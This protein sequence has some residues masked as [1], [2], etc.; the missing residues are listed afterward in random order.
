MLLRNAPSE[1]CNKIEVK[2]ESRESK[3]FLIFR[4]DSFPCCSAFL[5]AL[6]APLNRSNKSFSSQRNGKQ[7]RFTFYSSTFP[8]ENN[9]WATICS[10]LHRRKFNY[11]KLLQAHKVLEF[12]ANFRAFASEF[13][14]NKSVDSLSWAIVFSVMS[15]QLDCRFEGFQ[16]LFQTETERLLR[17]TS[18]S[19]QTRN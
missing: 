14:Q 16:F 10:F 9:F 3:K 12:A 19:K 8:E 2:S 6:T 15:K 18:T 7:L 1:K 13:M 5:Q 4:M 11:L 17:F